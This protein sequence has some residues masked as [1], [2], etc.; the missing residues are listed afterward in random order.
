MSNLIIIVTVLAVLYLLF[1]LLGF[2]LQDKLIYFPD[3]TLV[4][5]PE[6]VGLSYQ[7]VTFRAEDGV[8]LHGWFVPA[9]AARA[10]LLFCH[11]NA[12]NI[13]G[14]LESLSL[15]HS[16]GLAVFIFDY[17]G[18]GR[19]HG[20]PNEAGTYADA[21]AAWRYLTEQKQVAAEHIVLCGRS[22]GG[23]VAIELA[24]HVRPR[25]L[26]VESAFTSAAEL[27]ARVYPWLPV[28]QLARIRY[29]SLSRVGYIRC[30]KLFVHSL[31][32]D[33][34]PYSLGLKLFQRAREPKQML[35]IRGSHNDGF[36]TSGRKYVD[37]LESFLNGLEKE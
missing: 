32:D 26:I 30:P 3:R 1:C 29:D 19:S 27:G 5:T 31:H 9:P 12:G 35:K 21:R 16:L 24:T 33:V 6:H 10:V 28:R 8:E 13:S 34:V 36:L 17:R 4:A 22:L 23:A 18:Y 25:A 2:A 15:F 7:D 37:G 20:K 14:R 11:G